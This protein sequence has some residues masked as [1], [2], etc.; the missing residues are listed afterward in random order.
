MECS[1]RSPPGICAPRYS[2]G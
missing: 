2:S 1:T